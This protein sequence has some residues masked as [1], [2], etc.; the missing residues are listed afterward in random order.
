MADLAIIKKASDQLAT[1][2]NFADVPDFQKFLRNCNFYLLQNCK[3][4]DEKTQT[5][6]IKQGDKVMN[7][8]S[9]SFF[10]A[11]VKAS[12]C[13]CNL[14]KKEG[15]LIFRDNKAEQEG[16]AI[17]TPHWEFEKK[18]YEELNNCSVYFVKIYTN[19][20]DKFYKMG[21]TSY[22]INIQ[23]K[24]NFTEKLTSEQ[25]TSKSGYS[26]KQTTTSLPTHYACVIKTENEQYSI[27]DSTENIEA[28]CNTANSPFYKNASS[29]DYMYYKAIF[30]KLK[31]LLP[32]NL[33]QSPD[34]EKITEYIDVQPIVNEKEK[35]EIKLQLTE[36]E[37]EI[38]DEFSDKQPEPE[39]DQPEKP[40]LV[41]G[42]EEWKRFLTSII[43]GKKIT[44]KQVELHYRM[45]D[46][47]ANKVKE[48]L[49]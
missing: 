20:G 37:K 32:T 27:V 31:K 21:E 26:Y 2:E 10:T 22:E 44:F 36:K 28:L 47:V 45:S 23:K 24:E 1:L 13:G 46:E 4:F 12:D 39:P 11:M 8:N 34:Y 16:A 29:A 42:S 14:A 38:A 48:L 49:K 25:K 17:F 19:F 9:L 41:E 15:Y 33:Q 5:I 35:E 40:E 30:R 3:G 7:I 43:S 18:Q 6:Q